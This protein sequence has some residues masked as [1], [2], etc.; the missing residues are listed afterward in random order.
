MQSSRIIN[1]R[2]NIVLS[3]LDNFITMLFQFVSRTLIVQVLSEEYLG[4]TSLFTAILQVLNMAELGFSGAIIYNMYK[5]MAEND[6]K[7][8]CGLLHYY[9]KI[10]RIVA[11][12]IFVAGIMLSPLLPLLISGDYPGEINVFTLYYLYLLNT[13]FS[14]MFSAYKS[15][16]L[17]VL[18]R[19]DLLKI[20]YSIGNMMQYL[21]QIISLIIFRN[22]YLFVFSLIIGT[23]FKNIATGFIAKHRFPQFV[24]YGSITHIQR[25]DILSRVKGLLVCNISNVTATSIDSIVIS[26]LLGLTSVA[27]YNNYITIYHAVSN[28]IA[29]IR[30]AMQP[31]VGNSVAIETKQKNYNDMLLWQFL[32]SIIATWCSACMIAVY[33]SFMAVWMGSDMLLKMQ[34]V[35]LLAT[36]LYVTVIQHSFYLYLNGN[37][38]W[39][40]MRWPYILSIGTN[41]LLNISLGKLFGITGIIFATLLSSFFYG[42]IWQCKVIL[43]SYFQKDTTEFYNR[44][45]YYTCICII[46]WVITYFTSQTICLNGIWGIVIKLIVCTIC[47]IVVLLI[48]Y[49]KT[50]EYDKA[51]HLLKKFLREK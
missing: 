7:T 26:T 21:L 51:K 13:V 4:L 3:Y 43:R 25:K 1:T 46:A 45:I 31:S 9:R 40:E 5:P 18:Q 15:A 24:C 27:I 6:V 19:M 50:S 44:Q 38:L 8:V 16:L 35:F 47:T 48:A 41:F 36:L 17:T 34:D 37:G 28:I 39:W 12:I 10:Y 14:Y 49:S 23:V 20:A 42:F 32:F 22:Y 30:F 29:L 11:C 2:R 33:Q